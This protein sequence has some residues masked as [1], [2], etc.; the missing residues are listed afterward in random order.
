VD[1]ADFWFLAGLLTSKCAGAAPEQFAEK[2][3]R[4]D[5]APEGATENAAFAVCLKAY[6]DTNRE[7]FSKL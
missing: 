5:A 3:E 7:F 4:A 1:V 2:F 6:P